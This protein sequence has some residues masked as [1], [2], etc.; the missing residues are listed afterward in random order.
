MPSSRGRAGTVLLLTALFD[1]AACS[2]LVRVRVRA[3]VEPAPS[4]SQRRGLPLAGAKVLRNPAAGSC[5]VLLEP[6]IQ[7]VQRLEKSNLALG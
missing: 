7:A 1:G 3:S 5:I 4:N 6:A 2:G